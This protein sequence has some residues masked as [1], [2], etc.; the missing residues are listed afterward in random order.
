LNNNQQS[1]P[2]SNMYGGL[3]NNY[4]ES[5]EPGFGGERSSSFSFSEKS[6]RVAFVRLAKAM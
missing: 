6:I 5:A 3:S 1:P 4:D 2:D